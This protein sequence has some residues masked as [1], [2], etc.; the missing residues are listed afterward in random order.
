MSAMS[1]STRPRVLDPT[2]SSVGRKM[3]VTYQQVIADPRVAFT[4]ADRPHGILERRRLFMMT[5]RY[6]ENKP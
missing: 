3:P 4:P 1:N 6:Q 2:V 5:R